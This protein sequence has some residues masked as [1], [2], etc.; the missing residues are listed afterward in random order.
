MNLTAKT[1][2]V[3]LQT[4]S[5]SSAEVQL[6]FP[7]SD[8]PA[9]VVGSGAYVAHMIDL[10]ESAAARLMRPYLRDGESSFVV[11]MRLN[12]A[13]YEQL[14]ASRGIAVRAIA[15][16]RGAA[17]R[18]HRFTLHAFDECGLIG[19]AEQTR[20]VV[21][22]RRFMALARKRAGRRSLLLDV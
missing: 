16:H 21:A 10:M 20:A 15:I 6:L 22:Q 12:Q 1:A 13:A 7:G 3:T 11:E 8:F 14:D 4:S 5:P 9:V 17:A 18:L 2:E 19:S